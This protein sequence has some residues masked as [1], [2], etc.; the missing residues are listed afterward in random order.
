MFVCVLLLHVKCSCVHDCQ[1]HVIL[2]D[3]N[4]EGDTMIEVF[5]TALPSLKIE[6]QVDVATVMGWYALFSMHCSHGYHYSWYTISI[7][8]FFSTT[9]E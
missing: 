6:L 9:G 3:N 5:L 2:T 1:H 8:Y 4:N 7:C